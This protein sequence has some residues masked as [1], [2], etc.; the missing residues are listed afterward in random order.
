MQVQDTLQVPVCIFPSHHFI[1][2]AIL[3]HTVLQVAN[4]DYSTVYE[5][6]PNM[7]GVKT[8]GEQNGLTETHERYT[9]RGLIN[10]ER[11]PSRTKAR[12][13]VTIKEVQKSVDTATSSSEV[14]P[15]CVLNPV[16]LHPG[17]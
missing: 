1:A 14:R 11:G 4:H 8:Q 12:E 10:T 3:M 2:L 5:E 9:L 7:E 16:V 13:I 6:L 17:M 15:T